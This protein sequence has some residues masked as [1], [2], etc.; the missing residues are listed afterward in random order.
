MKLS[1]HKLIEVI[2]G[3]TARGFGTSMLYAVWIIFLADGFGYIPECFHHDVYKG[4]NWVIP[5]KL[6][7]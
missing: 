5:Q 1:E 6:A 4:E 3:G 7:C 2:H